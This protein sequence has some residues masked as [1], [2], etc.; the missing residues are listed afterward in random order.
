MRIT[1]NLAGKYAGKG[2]LGTGRREDNVKKD[3]K[4]VLCEGGFVWLSIL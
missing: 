2:V 3:I 4:K 1:Q